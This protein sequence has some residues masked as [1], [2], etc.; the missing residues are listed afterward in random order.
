MRIRPEYA[1]EV[2]EIFFLMQ[3]ELRQEAAQARREDHMK[4]EIVSPKSTSSSE[5][6]EITA[7]KPSISN[8]CELT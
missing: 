2:A 5:T 6:G 1:V 4:S 7:S 8:D 3:R